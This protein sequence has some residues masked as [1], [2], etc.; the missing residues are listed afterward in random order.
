MNP[1]EV[2]EEEEEEEERKSKLARG[3]YFNY[4]GRKFARKIYRGWY[5]RRVKEK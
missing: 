3:I 4:A 2:Q 1:V 5:L